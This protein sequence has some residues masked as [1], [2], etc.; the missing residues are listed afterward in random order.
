MEKMTIYMSTPTGEKIPVEV[1][2]NKNLTNKKQE[3][4][5]KQ[6]NNSKL[7]KALATAGVVIM[8]GSGALSG[9]QLFTNNKT[10]DYTSSISQTKDEN[11]NNS[12]FEKEDVKEGLRFNPNSKEGIIEQAVF[13]IEEAARCG[14]ELDPE[15]AVLAVI[16]ANSGELSLGFMGELFGEQANQVYTYDMITDSYLKACL[17]QVETVG[18]SKND[19][20]AF[21][22]ENVFASDEDYNYLNTMRELTIKFN[23]ST[24]EAERNQII[25]ELNQMA[26]KLCTYDS[27]DISSPAGVLAM[28]SLD[29]MRIVTNPLDTPILHDDIRDEMFGNHMYSCKD[30][31]VLPTA[32]SNRVS[33]LKLD[34]LK[35]KLKGAVLAEG[36]TVILDE[37]ISLVAEQTK[38]VQISDFDAAAEIN[39][40]LNSYIK[41]APIVKP[42]PEN[43]VPTKP[44]DNVTPEKPKEEQKTGNLDVTEPEIPSPEIDPEAPVI[45]PTIIVPET[46]MPDKPDIKVEENVTPEP[47]EEV[48]DT[49]D[50]DKNKEEAEEELISEWEKAQE[51]SAKGSADGKRYGLAG[52]G[53]PSFAGK[54]QYYINAFNA[55]YDVYYQVYLDAKEQEEQFAKEQE[56]AAKIEEKETINEESV[57]TETVI[58]NTE[59]IEEAK[60]IDT[61]D[62]DNLSVDELNALRDAALGAVIESTEESKTYSK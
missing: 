8:L 18:V 21:N 31:N 52:S 32:Y 24:S 2:V 4:K 26:L 1:K 34:N 58:E 47:D 15:D 41:E 5:S 60:T 37:I 28:L 44:S 43:N 10:D 35:S 54:S 30:S 19:N 33:D 39:K 29:G 20:I 16:A 23:N 50:V 62:L 38:D 55:S 57:E 6:V 51:D 56:E 14:K 12:D 13:L 22:I 53:K 59:T 42:N 7:R 11:F 17:I 3:K 46:P 36:K 9:C 27:L 40:I 45:K 61:Y 25:S 48:I 49:G